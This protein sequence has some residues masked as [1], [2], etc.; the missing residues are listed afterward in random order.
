LQTLLEESTKL[1]VRIW[2]GQNRKRLKMDSKIKSVKQII[3][4][5]VLNT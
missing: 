1:H 3:L 4:A 5:A 2:G